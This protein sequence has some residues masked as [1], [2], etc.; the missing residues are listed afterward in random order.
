MDDCMDVDPPYM[1]EDYQEENF[2]EECDQTAEEK[3]VYYSEQISVAEFHRHAD[4]FTQNELRKLR[5]SDDFKQWHQ[6]C[7]RWVKN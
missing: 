4:D 2:G 6:T 5:R 3:P 1:I 7:R